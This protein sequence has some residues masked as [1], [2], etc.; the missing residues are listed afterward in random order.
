MKCCVDQLETEEHLKAYDF[1]A[2]DNFLMIFSYKK[3]RI[4]IQSNTL[5]DDAPRWG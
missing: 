3:A 1:L 5:F 2:V 4:F